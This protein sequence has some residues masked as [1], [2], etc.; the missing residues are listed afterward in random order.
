VEH[1]QAGVGGDDRGFAAP[2]LESQ[3][4]QPISFA[5]AMV[6]GELVHVLCGQCGGIVP[7]VGSMQFQEGAQFEAGA[8]HVVE[9][10]GATGTAW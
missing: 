4:H 1:G 7:A 5:A 6:G 8:P 9:R 10:A 3:R 2:T